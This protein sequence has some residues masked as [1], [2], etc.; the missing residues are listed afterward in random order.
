MVMLMWFRGLWAQVQAVTR[1]IARAG[2]IEPYIYGIKSNDAEWMVLKIIRICVSPLTEVTSL[3][4]VGEMHGPL[5]PGTDSTP[6]A[7]LGV[8]G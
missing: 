5:T 3:E 8:V 1:Y 4:E 7:L 6:H 2:K